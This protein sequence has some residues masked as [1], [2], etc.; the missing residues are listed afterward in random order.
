MVPGIVQDRSGSGAVKGVLL[1]RFL[2]AVVQF[3]TGYSYF[4]FPIATWPGDRRCRQKCPFGE[5]HV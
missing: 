2:Q 1:K 4:G 5:Y 3:P